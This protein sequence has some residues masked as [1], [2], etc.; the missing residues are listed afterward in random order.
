MIP[1]EFRHLGNYPGSSLDTTP[2]IGHID[3]DCK[4]PPIGEGND[5]N[6]VG[7]GAMTGRIPDKPE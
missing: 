1:G 6:I 5:A 2:V 3:D 7:G 4:T